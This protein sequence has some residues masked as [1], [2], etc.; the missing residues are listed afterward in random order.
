MNFCKTLNYKYIDKKKSDVDTRGIALNTK[1]QILLGN[2]TAAFF[3][4]SIP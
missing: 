4:Q 3:E 2:D 1:P